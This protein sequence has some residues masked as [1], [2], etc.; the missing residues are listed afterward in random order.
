MKNLRKP[1]PV[2]KQYLYLNTA[3]SGLLSEKVLEFRQD[4]DLDFLISGSILKEKQ[5]EL[6][7][8][9]RETVSSFFNCAPNRVALVPNF[10]FGFNTLMEGIEK[11]EK[12]LLLD[13]DY[14]S[15]NWAVTSR[16][17]EICTAAIDENIE[18][19][20]EDAIKEHEPNVFAFSIV[21]YINGIK[22]SI[23]FLR[24]LKEKFPDILFIADGTQYCGTEK[25]DFD[26]SKLDVLIASS[27]KWLNGG[28]GNAFMLFQENV[29]DKISPKSCGF[30]S[31]QGK[32]KAHEGNF[33]GK[34]EPGHLD[35]LNFGSL[36][37]ALKFLKE[38]GMEQVEE[39][40]SNLSKL[41]KQQFSELGLLEEMVQKRDQH[42][43]IFNIKG[44]TQL[45]NF[46]R[47]E[48]ILCS[49]RGQGIRLSFHYF[50]TEEELDLLI[51]TLRQYLKA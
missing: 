8:E 14:P 39:R 35:T 28:Y 15:I 46:L 24:N 18:H 11:S 1:F 27:Y 20:I 10:S 22:L 13:G 41:A 17:F 5:G 32:Y 33:I 40:V 44:D 9:V 48:H 51:K 19:N 2:L 30:N 34:F 12:V 42:S 3:A 4:H 50:N 45:Y 36:N 21:Q 47:G 31:L 23:D 16:E 49:Q 25:F 37:T 43:S 38:I 29:P 26:T 6:L 7:T